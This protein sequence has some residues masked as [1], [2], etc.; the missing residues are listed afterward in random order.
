MVVVAWTSIAT[1]SYVTLTAHF[2]TD[3]WQLASNVLQTRAIY[4]S[5]TGP[6]KRNYRRYCF[7]DGLCP[8]AK[9][10]FSESSP[11]DQC[12]KRIKTF[13]QHDMIAECQLEEK[14]KL[15]GFLCH[16]LINVPQCFDASRH[17]DHFSIKSEPS[18]LNR[19]VWYQEIP[20]PNGEF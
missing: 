7:S 5:R 3:D 2:V 15:L 19:I 1:D 17:F 4:E 16:N 8:N 14:Q 10:G 20:T 11:V 18:E 6:R 13:F 9:S 12:I